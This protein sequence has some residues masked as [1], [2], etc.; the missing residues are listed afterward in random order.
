MLNHGNHSAIKSNDFFIW[1]NMGKSQIK[2]KCCVKKL[3]QNKGV[4]DR[5]MTALTEILQ[6][7]NYSIMSK[8]KLLYNVKI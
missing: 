1:N 2:K 5:C 8:Y 4:G 6:N 3:N 7:I